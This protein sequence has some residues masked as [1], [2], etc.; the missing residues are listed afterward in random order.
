[1]AKEV[2][3]AGEKLDLIFE[4]SNDATGSSKAEDRGDEMQTDLPVKL[5]SSIQNVS[6][7]LDNN[8]TESKLDDNAILPEKGN[9]RNKRKK[10]SKFV[11]SCKRTSS[12]SKFYTG[13]LS[14]LVKDFQ[15]EERRCKR[16]ESSSYWDRS[17]TWL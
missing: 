15:C 11:N 2:L 13:R 9:K 1:M 5:A 14:N 10:K 4:E 17:S 8:R 7:P 3:R 16:A 6:M 12:V